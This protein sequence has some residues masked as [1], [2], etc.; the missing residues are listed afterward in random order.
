MIK[1]IKNNF[2]TISLALLFIVACH[3]QIIL[4][5]E[6]K[7]TITTPDGT[8][9]KAPEGFYFDN[10]NQDIEAKTEII[11]SDGTVLKAP[12]GFYFDDSNQDVFEEFNGVK[13][14]E[15]RTVLI[16][17]NDVTFR[18]PEGFTFDIEDISKN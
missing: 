11:L 4:H 12:E 13:I 17:R 9:L 7:T 2:I 6:A 15:N 10:S 18:A 3:K 1:I 5:A 14:N 16:D 8:V